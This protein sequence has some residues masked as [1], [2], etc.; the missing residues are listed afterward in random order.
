MGTSVAVDLHDRGRVTEGVLVSQEV[1]VRKGDGNAY[2]PQFNEPLHEGV[3]F[4]VTNRRRG[5]LHI[6]LPDGNRGWINERDA[7]TF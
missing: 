7:E 6:E 4:K 3:E 2:E 1:I 5:W